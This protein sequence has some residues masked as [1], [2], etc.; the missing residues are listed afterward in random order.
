MEYRGG[1]EQLSAMF[2]IMVAENIQVLREVS[3]HR[4]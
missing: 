2:S 4:K 3:E 1:G